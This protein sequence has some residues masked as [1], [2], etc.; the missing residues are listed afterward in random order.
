MNFLNIP[1]VWGGL[2]AAGVAVPIIIH[3]LY[4]KHKRQT[5]WAAMELLRKALVIRSGQVRLEDYLLLFLRCL[6]LAL[7]AFALLRPT[8]HTSGGILSSGQQRVG[9]VVAIDASYSMDHGNLAKRFEEA[10]AKAREIL[11]TIR[12]GDPTTVMLMGN[13]PRMILR[14]TGYDEHRFNEALEQATVSPERLNIDRCLAE[15]VELVSELKTPIRECYVITD[16]QVADW[17]SISDEAR[18]RIRQIT[19]IANLYIIPIADKGSE[20]LAVTRFEYASG[21]LRQSGMARF[22]A[23]IHNYGHHPQPD[24][25]ATFYMYDPVAADY[26]AIK[27]QA[28][29]TIDPG[30]A[31]VVSFFAPLDT[32]GNQRLKISLGPD[33]LNL[34][35]TRHAVVDVRP[36]IKVLCVDGDPSAE[37]GKSELFFA[38]RALRLKQG[39]SGAGLD[40]TSTPW[41]DLPAE[42]FSQYDVILLANV[43]GMDEAMGKSLASFVYRGGGLIVFSGDQIDPEAYNRALQYEGEPLLPGVLQGPGEARPG[44]DP[45]WRLGPITSDHVLARAAKTLS[46]AELDSARFTRSAGIKVQ[47]GGRT[48]LS[49]TGRDRPLLLEKITGRG[50]VLLFTTTADRAWSNF[51]IHPMYPMILQ[52]ALTHLTSRIDAYQFRVG[53]SAAIA[54]NGVKAESRVQ[55]VDPRG[56][57]STVKVAIREGSAPAVPVETEMPGI[58][59]AEVAEGS[60]SSIAVNIHPAEADVKVMLAPALERAI[61]F[62]DVHVV[63]PTDALTT[64]IKHNRIGKELS[65]LLLILAVLLFLAQSWLARYFTRRMRVGETDVTESMRQKTVAAG[66]KA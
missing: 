43:P 6:L 37:P 38:V 66:R 18:A 33:D 52:Q 29:G 49:L 58:Y 47:D 59:R 10:G 31:K 7:V 65:R 51:P 9:A 45:A 16:A 24:G 36:G 64:V 25:S 40:V 3:L 57:E 61:G 54:M 23:E 17:A 27:R 2:G 4:R 26:Q 42:D 46:Q 1:L 34:D 8:L 11:S 35:N 60:A 13:R 53:D 22:S 14:A 20:N 21:S 32:I 12:V 41:D 63:A 44:E 28:L 39:A 50:S 30:K 55:L 15:M 5:D 56:R 48:I 19:G 62:E